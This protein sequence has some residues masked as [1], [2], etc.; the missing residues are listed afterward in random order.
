ML[1]I[2]CCHE[3]RR[4][5]S[6]EADNLSRWFYHEVC[7]IELAL[8]KAQNVQLRVPLLQ[9]RSHILNLC[10]QW[11]STLLPQDVLHDQARRAQTVAQSLTHHSKQNN[12]PSSSPLETEC[13]TIVQDS[14]EFLHSKD[15][16]QPVDLEDSVDHTIDE[17]L[18]ADYLEAKHEV[19]ETEVIAS[20]GVDV[21]LIWE[22]PELS[23]Q[24]IQ[25]F[26]PLSKPCSFPHLC[27]CF[28]FGARE[29]TIM[30]SPTAWLNDPRT[31][32]NKPHSPGTPPCFVEL[33][34]HSTPTLANSGTFSVD[35]DSPLANSNVF[36]TA[37]S[38][39]LGLPE[40]LGPLPCHA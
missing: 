6:I 38:T 14:N 15:I 31:P 5:L 10:N 28:V 25:E 37:A 29:L 27:G 7:A 23:F 1:K 19:P 22:L 30:E 9:H 35:S 16:E 26:E 8:N 3:E 18:L 34:Q 32:P 13:L 40:P 21:T 24:T 39:S 36:P 12:H 4:R 33:P 11:S 17:V 2:D 20:K